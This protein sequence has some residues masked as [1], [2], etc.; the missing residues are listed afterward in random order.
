MIAGAFAAGIALTGGVAY[1][2]IPSGGVISGC[3]NQT[4][5]NMRLLVSSSGSCRPDETSIQWNQTGPAGQQG[6]PGPA[7]PQ[8]LPGPVGLSGAQGSKGDTGAKGDT[9]LV[10]PS[11]PAGVRG[12]EGP[13]GPTGP[14]GPPGPSGPQGDQGA[15]GPAG[16]SLASLDD[17]AGTPCNQGAGTLSVLYH[18]DQGGAVTM[19][20]AA[21]TTSALSV[22]TTGAGTVTSDRGGIDCGTTCNQR[23]GAGTVVRLTA[24]PGPGWTFA[25]WS[26]ACSGTGTCAITLD[27]DKTVTALFQARLTVNAVSLSHSYSY[28]CGGPF[29]PHTCFGSIGG[30]GGVTSTPAGIACGI[31]PNAGTNTCSAVFNPDTVVTL[32]ADPVS[33]SYFGGWGGDGCTAI[34]TT[35]ALTCTITM[36]RAQTVSAS[37][38][39]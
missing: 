21:T 33:G 10:G 8:G 16:S 34:T 26:G 13:V 28:E 11:G 30:S 14:A 23:F 22:T 29:D 15:A 18:P 12:A 38:G 5:G 19:T 25:G 37:F 39:A 4:N 32:T 17:L 9:G 3:Y 27:A 31:Y 36:S 7:G 6:I 24:T 20:C 35:P 1:A 2:A